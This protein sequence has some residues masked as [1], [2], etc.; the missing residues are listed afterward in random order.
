MQQ[1][2]VDSVRKRSAG[3]LLYRRRGQSIEVFLVHPGGP[4]FKNKDAGAWSIPKGEYEEGEPPFDTARR[5]FH[6]ET[7]QLPPAG[8]YEPLTPILQK[9]RKRVR[10]WAVEGDADAETI[11]SNT[12]KMEW[13]PRSGRTIEIPE[14]DRAAWYSP[15]TARD[16][17]NPAQWA[18]VEELLEKLGRSSTDNGD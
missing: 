13:P 17:I 15:D 5:E 11:V 6:E 16:K 4:Y 1:H 9:N 2:S 8:G 7:G 18:L 3:L 14:V 10:A 12:F